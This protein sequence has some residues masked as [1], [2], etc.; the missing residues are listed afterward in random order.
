[1]R[2][3]FG[4]AIN[5]LS[6]AQKAIESKL[7][8]KSAV[9]YEP[10]KKYSN[11]K[12]LLLPNVNAL[13]ANLKKLEAWDGIAVVFDSP[14]NLHSISKL[15]WLDV[16]RNPD[17]L[18]YKFEFIEP[19]FTRL[20]EAY[21]SKERKVV[22]LKKPDI[23]RAL[24]TSRNDTHFLERW[25]NF[26][27]FCTSHVNREYCKKSLLVYLNDKITL[28]KLRT[29]LSSLIRPDQVDYYQRELLSWLK[30]EDGQRLKKA[31]Q[32]LGDSK[33]AQKIAKK[34]N[35]ELADLRYLQRTVRAHKELVKWP[36]EVVVSAKKK[37]K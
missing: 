33:E 35:V 25:H 2:Q 8:E 19:N 26:L 4:I 7:G 10:K 36:V 22:K 24:I 37:G 15:E 30:S 6:Y 29:E 31:W 27:Y 1:M 28:D 13:R 3:L 32:L 18:S 11:K 20:F 5:S 17:V 14:T 16:K 34:S 21:E 23:L 12:V 9:L